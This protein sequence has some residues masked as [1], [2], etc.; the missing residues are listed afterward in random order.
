M[1]AWILGVLLILAC[2]PAHAGDLFGTSGVEEWRYA[3]AQ[4]NP[5]YVL[6]GCAPSVPGSGLALSPFACTAFVTLADGRQEAVIQPAVG[7]TLPAFGDG[8]YWLLAYRDTGSAVANWTRSAVGA[9]SATRYLVRKSA[10]RPADVAG[11]LI[12]ARLDVAGGNI[13]N[14]ALMGQRGGRPAGMRSLA[15]F[16]GAGDGVTDSAQALQDALDSNACVYIPEGTWYIPR[17][18]TKAGGTVCLKGAGMGKTV[19][20]SF[21]GVIAGCSGNYSYNIL[22]L[23]NPTAVL[24]EDMTFDGNVTSVSA[25]CT[26]GSYLNQYA[27][28]DVSGGTNVTLDRVEWTKFNG[29]VPINSAGGTMNP[30]GFISNQKQGPLW[31]AN[32][33]KILIADNRL[34]SP[35]FVE[36]LTIVE[37]SKG[38]VRG[39]LSTAGRDSSATYGTSSPLRILGITTAAREWEVTGSYIKNPNGSWLGAYLDGDINVHNNQIVCDSANLKLGYCGGFNATPDL[40]NVGSAEAPPERVLP[41][42]VPIFDHIAYHHNI[43]INANTY[44]VTWGRSA[45]TPVVTKASYVRIHHNVCRGAWIGIIGGASAV[46]DVYDNLVSEVLQYNAVGTYGSAI[47]IAQA[48]SDA[49]IHGNMIDGTATVADGAGL[50][51]V[52]GGCKT[53]YGV[54]MLDCQR[55]EIAGNHLVGAADGNILYAVSGADDGVYG[56]LRVTDNYIRN[57]V[58][59]PAVP[60][61]IGTDATHRV[62]SAYIAGNSVN[63]LPL[64]G[65]NSALFIKTTLADEGQGLR[66]SRSS[67]QAIPNGLALTTVVFPASVLNPGLEYNST[68]GVYT[69]KVRGLYFFQ[70]NLTLEALEDTKIVL[71]YLF[72]DG[73]SARGGLLCRNVNT[74]GATTDTACIGGVFVNAIPGDTIEVKLQHNGTAATLDVGSGA[75]FGGAYMGRN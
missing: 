7:L 39:L 75:V 29:T 47:T 43:Q 51:N 45:I 65:G 62:D 48:T 38:V 21:A 31:I 15:E 30:S 69:V 49:R 41:A 60:V 16:G 56:N 19:L 70:A 32:S 57:E 42:D 74:T 67:G 9:T 53:R 25:Y 54:V 52:V 12:F 13:A 64:N 40:L 6:S 28:L 34:T 8:V 14:V 2:A 68:T 50:C 66:A 10:T 1:L 35:S 58:V 73:S 23:T 26:T 3:T 37:S 22:A 63:G 55:C 46:V 44:C 72:V 33:S 17:S 71:A 36:G 27:L 18:V 59:V 61:Q 4:D 24:I 20:K 5:N 11:G